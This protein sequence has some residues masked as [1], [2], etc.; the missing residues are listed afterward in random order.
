M[1]MKY[2]PLSVLLSKLGAVSFFRFVVITSSLEFFEAK[3]VALNTSMS[4]QFPK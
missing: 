3:F 2:F 4:N 1:Q